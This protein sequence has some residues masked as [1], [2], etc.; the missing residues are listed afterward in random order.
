[1]KAS[2]LIALVTLAI[3]VY[4]APTPQGFG[5]VPIG[6]TDNV[7]N[8]FNNIP[9]INEGFGDIL[10]PFNDVTHGDSHGTTFLT[11]STSVDAPSFTSDGGNGGIPL[12][13]HFEDPSSAGV[14]DPHTGRISMSP[15]DG[16][17]IDDPYTGSVSMSP[18]GGIHV[19]GND[20]LVHP[21]HW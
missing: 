7:P 4:A 11:G 13:G 8:H 1:M 6:A 14:N 5:V 9:G 15:T 3:S 16:I 19:G 12:P 18:T 20:P 17:C 10:W 21:P 2:F